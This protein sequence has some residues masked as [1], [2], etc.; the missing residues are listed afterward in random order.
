MAQ[1]MLALYVEAKE[2]IRHGRNEPGYVMDMLSRLSTHPSYSPAGF[3]L[4]AKR[5]LAMHFDRLNEEE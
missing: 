5:L 3:G 1:S 2:E 4:L